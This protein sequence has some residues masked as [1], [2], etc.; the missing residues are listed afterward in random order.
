MP[1]N[2][3]EFFDSPN[4]S[5][6]PDAWVRA[7]IEE[8]LKTKK[9]GKIAVFNEFAPEYFDYYVRLQTEIAKRKPDEQDRPYIVLK[10]QGKNRKD[11][12]NIFDVG[13]AG[14]TGPLSDAELLSKLILHRSNKPTNTKMT[15]ENRTEIAN[16]CKNFSAVLYSIPPPRDFKHLPDFLRYR[17]NYS[18]VREQFP[19]Y[20]LQL[21]SN[22]A[23]LKI[24]MF[25]SNVMLGGG[26][27]GAV[28]DMTKYVVNVIADE[29]ISATTQN[30]FHHSSQPL[31]TEQLSQDRFLSVN[32][33]ER[34]ILVLGTKLAH[35]KKLY[36]NLIGEKNASHIQGILPQTKLF[37]YQ[38][39]EDRLQKIIDEIKSGKITDALGNTFIDF[40]IEQIQ[41]TETNALLYSC[42]EIPLLLGSPHSTGKTVQE[43][44]HKKLEEK[45]PGK[46]FL[47]YDTEDMFVK[48][49]DAM[50]KKIS[51]YDFID[52]A[53]LDQSG[54]DEVK[55]FIGRLV[56]KTRNATS[57]KRFIPNINK[58]DPDIKLAG[59]CQGK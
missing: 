26:T 42:T 29:T 41:R 34:K 2:T 18:A 23:H 22:T 13:L 53:S 7:H 16:D 59:A 57:R 5:M 48:R 40:V 6:A 17:D 9:D 20:S 52:Q 44:L 8:I 12:S 27:A 46:K 1:D 31:R 19:C 28:D 49:I 56:D 47:H 4:D 51:K 10:I 43:L 3:V 14:G 38:K 15:P 55:K 32:M 39:A 21:L 35:E 58:I 54:H 25:K 36:P 33:Q 45:F 24:G 30:T 11:K 50:Q 37:D